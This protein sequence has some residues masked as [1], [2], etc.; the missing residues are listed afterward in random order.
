MLIFGIW[1]M[2]NPKRSARL[3]EALLSNVAA[4]SVTAWRR[5]VSMNGTLLL[6][7]VEAHTD[8]GGWGGRERVS[9]SDAAV[10]GERDRVR[11]DWLSLLSGQLTATQLTAIQP[12]LFLVED[13]GTE[14]WN[15]EKMPGNQREEAPRSSQKAGRG[16]DL[17]VIVLRTRW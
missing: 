4:F 8:D 15:Y 10:F 5:H 13:T 17:P 11:F 16:G 14:Q 7:G 6:S 1:Y 9:A 2:T 3:A 12:T